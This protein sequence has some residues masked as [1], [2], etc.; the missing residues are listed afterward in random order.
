[1]SL[2]ERFEKGEIFEANNSQLHQ[3]TEER[4][5]QDEEIFELGKFDL[6][7]KH[8]STLIDIYVN[9]LLLLLFFFF[10]E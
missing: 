2:K 7:T 8:Q 1:M 3:I 10:F 5:K 4:K 9:G 6:F